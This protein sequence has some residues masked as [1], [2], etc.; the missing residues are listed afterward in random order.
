MIKEY[1]IAIILGAILGLGITGAFFALHRNNTK[2]NTTAISPVP[3]DTQM[4]TQVSATPSISEKKSSI[5]ITSPENNTVLSTTKTNIKGNTK[6]NSLIIIS[7]PSKT[8]SDKSNSNGVFNISIELDSGVNLI[9]I[10]SID[11]DDNQDETEITLT[12]STTKI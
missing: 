1:F 4:S 9:K 12:Y 6:P 8:F 7:T 2:Q 3:T 5:N 10:S 11:S